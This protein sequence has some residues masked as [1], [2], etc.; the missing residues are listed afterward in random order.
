MKI[1]AQTD[2]PPMPEKF[3]PGDV[4]ICKYNIDFTDGTSHKVGSKHTVT[5]QTVAYYNVMQSDYDKA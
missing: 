4:A 2:K 3:Q 1:V 5:E